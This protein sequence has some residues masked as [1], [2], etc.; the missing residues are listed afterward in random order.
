MKRGTKKCE[1]SSHPGEQSN[2]FFLRQRQQQLGRKNSLHNFFSS[3]N[4]RINV[5]ILCR[6]AEKISKKFCFS[7]SFYESYPVVGRLRVCTVLLIGEKFRCLFHFVK[8][9]CWEFFR[10]EKAEWTQENDLQEFSV[11]F[12]WI[13]HPPVWAWLAALLQWEFVLRSCLWFEIHLKWMEFEGVFGK[14]LTQARDRLELGEK[15]QVQL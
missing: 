9:N 10:N 12:R 5:N 1:K 11:I 8:R 13:L 15:A 7:S 14:M 4:S 3:W 2:N 6:A